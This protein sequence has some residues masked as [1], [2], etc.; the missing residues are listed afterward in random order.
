MDE[1]VIEIIKAKIGDKYRTQVALKLAEFE[2]EIE[3]V[4][5]ESAEQFASTYTKSLSNITHSSNKE[6]K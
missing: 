2:H 4:V 1:P 6:L 3:A 5:D